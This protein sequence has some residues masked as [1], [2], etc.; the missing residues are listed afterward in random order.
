MKFI[1]NMPISIKVTLL[2]G[3]IVAACVLSLTLGSLKN[4]ATG[5]ASLAIP[6]EYAG[7]QLESTQPAYPLYAADFS[8]PQETISVTPAEALAVTNAFTRQSYIYFVVSLILGIAA[9]YIVVGKALRPVRQLNTMVHDITE[10]SLDTRIPE[11]KSMDEIGQL[12]N[13]FNNMLRRLNE[14]FNNQKRFSANAAHELKTP[15]AIMKTNLQV[16]KMADEPS[17]EEYRQCLNVTEESINRLIDIVDDLLCLASDAPN[18]DEDHIEL[19]QMLEAIAAD[20]APLYSDKGVCISIDCA[21]KSIRGSQL[22]IYRALSN[23]V[24]NAYKYTDQGGSISITTDGHNRLSISNTGP[25]I[26]QD[27]RDKI[28][29]PFYRVDPSRSRKTAGSGLGLSIT[30]AILRRHGA[31][32][33]LADGDETRFVIDFKV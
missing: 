28:F 17:A 9:V 25:G 18:E 4:A 30:Q 6:A 21:G 27:E 15:L 10:N 3:L 5:M 13:S 33:S 1:R 31:A 29:E 8:L 14:S 12:A 7:Y 23:L 2:T 26:P 16:T 22:L 11:S 32:I 24:E 20:I 19:Q